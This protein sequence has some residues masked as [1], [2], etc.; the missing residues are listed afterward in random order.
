MNNLSSYCGL[1]DGRKGAS[2]KDLPVQERVLVERK[3]IFLDKE[4]I[5]LEIVFVD[6]QHTCPEHM[7]QKLISWDVI[8]Q[9][10]YIFI[11]HLRIFRSYRIRETI[12]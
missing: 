3:E 7:S 8:N 1:V 2:D 10:Y 11:Q 12:R 9:M 5:F 4:V 6:T